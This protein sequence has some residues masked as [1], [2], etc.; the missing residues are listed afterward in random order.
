MKKWLLL[1]FG[2]LAVVAV[3]YAV[4]TYVRV[5]PPWAKPQF[6]AVSI[7]DITVPV[8]A[9]GLIEPYQRIEIKSEASGEVVDTPVNPGDFVHK[10]QVLLQIKEVDEQRNTDRAAAE[11]DRIEALLEQAKVGVTQAEQ[12]VH[13]AEAQIAQL[14]GECQIVEYEYNKVKDDP[15]NFSPQQLND[16]KARLDINRAQHKAARA[17]L[18][19]RK[20][21]VENARSNVKLQEAA[22][23]A[24]TKTYDD[25]VE[26]LRKTTIKSRYDAIV[27]D[28]FVKRGMLI[29]SATQGFTG[30]TRVMELADVSRI[31]VRAKIDE[32]EYGRILSIAPPD[33]L[34]DRPGMRDDAR[35]QVESGGQRSGAVTLTVDAFRDKKFAGQIER[36][37]PQGKQTAGSTVIQFDVQ[38]LVTDPEAHLLPLGAQAQV[39]FTIDKAEKVLRVPSEAIMRHRDQSGVWIKTDPPPGSELRYGKKFVPVRLGISDNEF[40]EIREVLGGGELKDGQQVYTKLPREAEKEEDERE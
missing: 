6:G 39:E 11:K 24:A 30:G 5:D 8:L 37:E 23:R 31:I 32:S 17:T 13:T 1:L 4:R 36:L 10:D 12:E 20:L 22:L 18:E 25:A 29:Q 27:T 26:R 35:S 33:A 28:V 40:T 9:S 3:W 2:A 15:K 21:Q 38:V 7:G 16:A 19:I 34:P 14:E